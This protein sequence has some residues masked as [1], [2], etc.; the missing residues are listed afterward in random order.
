MRIKDPVEVLYLTGMLQWERTAPLD[1]RHGFLG[2]QPA[3]NTQISRMAYVL[4]LIPDGSAEHAF[5]D[6]GHAHT[7]K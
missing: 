3:Q 6:V 1:G 2:D 4:R 7:P 5:S